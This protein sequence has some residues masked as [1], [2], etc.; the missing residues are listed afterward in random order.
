MHLHCKVIIGKCDSYPYCH[1]DLG[2]DLQ[3]SIC[4]LGDLMASHST[5]ESL[6][7]LVMVILCKDL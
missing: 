1:R 2:L 3:P 6:S 5:S 4:K 7:F